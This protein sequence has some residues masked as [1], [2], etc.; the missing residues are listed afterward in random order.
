MDRKVFSIEKKIYYHDTDCGGVVYYANYL[1]FLEESRTEFFLKKGVDLKEL[2]D[3]KIWFVV[4]KAQVEYKAPARYQD[5]IKI[6]CRIKDIKK[7]SIAIYQEILK[8]S[9]ILVKAEISLVCINDKFKP[10]KVPA[11]I[12]CRLKRGK[13]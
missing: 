5:T 2:Q 11:E 8:K 10:I 4:K 9:F 3:S 7:A 13:I 1:K 6:T 12:M